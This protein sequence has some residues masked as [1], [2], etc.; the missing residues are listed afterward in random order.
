MVKEWRIKEQENLFC[1]LNVFDQEWN[2]E[3]SP[4]FSLLVFAIKCNQA[5]ILIRLQ[6]TQFKKFG[7]NDTHDVAEKDLSEPDVE[8]MFKC[9]FFVQSIEYK[10]SSYWHNALCYLYVHMQI[11]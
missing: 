7:I 9:S 10:R 8:C 1:H 4:Y 3:V 2:F 6:P 5:Y 11:S